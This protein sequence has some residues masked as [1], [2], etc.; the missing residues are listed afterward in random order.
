M[1]ISIPNRDHGRPF[2]PS[3]GKWRPLGLDEVRIEGGFWGELQHLNATVMIEHC[4]AWIER[5][6][7]AGNFDAAVQ[8][9]LPAARRGREFSDSEVYKLLEAMSWLFYHIP[10]TLSVYFPFHMSVNIEH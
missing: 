6:G 9:R 7:W 10:S 4:E 8:G 5:M 2:V 3:H 1:S